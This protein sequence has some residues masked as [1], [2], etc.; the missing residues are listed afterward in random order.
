MLPPTGG[1]GESSGLAETLGPLGTSRD[2]VESAVIPGQWASTPHVPNML[3]LQ[4]SSTGD[5]EPLPQAA[6]RN[7]QNLER[8]D[9]FPSRT[10]CWAQKMPQLPVHCMSPFP[11]ASEKV[12]ESYCGCTSPPLAFSPGPWCLDSSR[13]ELGGRTFETQLQSHQ[14]K[15]RHVCKGPSGNLWCPAFLESDWFVPFFYNDVTPTW[16]RPRC[17][18]GRRRRS[19]A[20]A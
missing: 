1:P 16:H 10:G 20:S 14:Q 12:T 17:V 11:V 3:L 13:R 7:R 19:W 5:R 8:G 18:S 15:H 4:V 2:T 9:F 6:E